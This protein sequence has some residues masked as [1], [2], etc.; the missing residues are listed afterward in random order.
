MRAKV[1]VLFSISLSGFVRAQNCPGP[2][3]IC[4]GDVIARCVKGIWQS[5]VCRYGHTCTSIP[6]G[7]AYC[8]INQGGSATQGI[9]ESGYTQTT[10]IT[11]YTSQ[12][13]YSSTIRYTTRYQSSS[14]STIAPNPT[15]YSQINPGY[16]V[17]NP[18]YSTSNVIYASSQ[19]TSISYNVDTDAFPATCTNADATLSISGSTSLSTASSSANLKIMSVPATLTVFL[20]LLYQI[21]N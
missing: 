9:Q 3:T 16:S 7:N 21:M 2:V 8:T 19:D 14:V 13:D 1:I 4:A 12:D 6:Y 5:S 10:P 17:P 15:S 20:A 18:P 11:P